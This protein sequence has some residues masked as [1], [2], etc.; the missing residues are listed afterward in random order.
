[1]PPSRL[2]EGMCGQESRPF[3]CSCGSAGEILCLRSVIVKGLMEQGVQPLGFILIPVSWPL[4]SFLEKQ[5][6]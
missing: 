3:P 6:K 2:P 4:F 1:M 5:S